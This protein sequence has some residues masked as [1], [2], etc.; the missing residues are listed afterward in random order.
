MP[1][2]PL[3]YRSLALF[4]L[5]ESVVFFASYT[6]PGAPPL[7]ALSL[8]VLGA[9]AFVLCLWCS[10]GVAWEVFCWAQMA[11]FTTEIVWF[12]SQD[13]LYLAHPLG[14]ASKNLPII[15]LLLISLSKNPKRGWVEAAVALV[16]LTEGLFPKILFQQTMELSM[17]ESF[18]GWLLPA[19]LGL[20]LIGAAQIAS[21]VLVLAT[22]LRRFILPLQLVA[23]V[24]LPLLVIAYQPT[25][26]LFWFA[27]LWK[28]LP[29]IAGTYWLITEH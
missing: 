5:L 26:A 4:W 13:W 6:A 23:L 28:N 18:L 3:L 12:A 24:A 1:F 25:Y 8:A 9:L 2:K 29:I 15:L 21:G 14:L 19:S 27:P 22:P 10:F 11:W 17:A 7:S 16:W 20:K